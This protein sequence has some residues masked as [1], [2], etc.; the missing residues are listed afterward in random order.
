MSYY[1]SNTS[2]LTNEQSMLINI[3]NTMYSDNLRQINSLNNTLDSLIE[4]N[5]QIRILLTQIL[6]NNSTAN[7]QQSR[8]SRRTSSR[9]EN[10]TFYTNR[11]LNSLGRIMINN[12]PYIIDSVSEYTIPRNTN[13]GN[14]YT[15]LDSYARNIYDDLLETFLQPIVVHPTQSQ[16]ESAT[17][18]V[19]YCDI[20][21]PINTSCP[22]SMEE[23][24]DTDMVT[25]IRQ[26]GHIFDTDHLNNWFRSNC[27]CPVCRYDIREYNSNAS[28]QFFSNSTDVSNNYIERNNQSRRNNQRNN[29]QTDTTLLNHE[30]GNGMTG[31]LNDLYNI[32]GLI[33]ASGNF[34]NSSTDAITSFLINAISN[35][36]RNT[37]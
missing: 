10:N 30:L 1:N 3:L 17:S 16:I 22:I 34:I 35:R 28:T 21:R 13:R 23:F 33:D 37:R 4:S 24:N 20:A 6:N 15:T 26:C 9:R 36:T 8:D 11:N 31:S 7:N 27:R 19:R 25:V 32:T 29:N 14:S 12:Q 2:R 18:R 5:N